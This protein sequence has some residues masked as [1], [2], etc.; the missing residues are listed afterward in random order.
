MTRKELT[1]LRCI[2]RQR[3]ERGSEV[4]S[5]CEMIKSNRTQNGL[6]EVKCNTPACE[7]YLE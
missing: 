5:Y 6:K 1:C 2:H 7:L 3:W 4:I